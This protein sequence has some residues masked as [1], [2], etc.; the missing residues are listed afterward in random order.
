MIEYRNFE[1]KKEYKE[2][3]E[4][5]IPSFGNRG[6][7]LMLEKVQGLLLINIED[8]SDYIEIDDYF[9]GEESNIKRAIYKLLRKYL[10]R[11]LDWGMLVG[12]NPLKLFLKL[13]D[14][15]GR[16]EAIRILKEGYF[17]SKVKIDLG[18]ETID[19]QRHMRKKLEGRTS[20]YIDIPFCPSKCSYC[21]YSTYR[22]DEELIEDYIE[23]LLYEMKVISNKLS[24]QPQNIYIGGGT[25][26]AI[27]GKYLNQV[28]EGIAK[29]FSGW[30]ELT[31]EIGRPDTINKNIL[32]LLKSY[33]VD[34]ISINP[35]T[36]K[37][38]TLKL[39][40]RDHSI[41]D[42]YRAF[43]EARAMG[44]DN[45]N[46][47]LIIGLPGE[48]AN[49]FRE[50]LQK[51]KELNPESLSIHALAMKKG[52][53]LRDSGFL[54]PEEKEFVEVRDKY[55]NQEAYRPYYLYRQKNMYLNIENIGYSKDGYESFHNVA[56]MEDIQ[57]IIGLGLA[58]STKLIKKGKIRRHM[59]YRLMRDYL[60]KID[61]NIED[62]VKIWEENK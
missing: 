11:D 16:E 35:Q 5:F 58:S 62:K 24:L 6:L 48:D 39:L 40:G 17:L 53:K 30:E 3:I 7:I 52:S 28:L 29:Y 44:F 10:R 57:S 61:R 54:L 25:P 32:S 13:E 59:N 60:E 20:L 22:Y 56:M 50:T 42:I 36:M 23:K 33:E 21:S 9:P 51:I 37:E 2:L 18:F 34:R 45:I 27:G 12:V 14:R 15:L 55:I 43:K 49:I 1:Y 38:E 8:Y 41:L 31:V 26:S 4:T 19:N 46:A 47:D